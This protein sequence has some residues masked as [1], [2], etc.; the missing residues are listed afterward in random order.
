MRD[1]PKVALEWRGIT[2]DAAG[3]TFFRKY[4]QRVMEEVANNCSPWRGRRCPLRRRRQL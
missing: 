1:S 4:Q 2:D 3:K